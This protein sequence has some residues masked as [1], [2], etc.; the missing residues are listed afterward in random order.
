M[1]ITSKFSNATQQEGNQTGVNFADQP[2]TYT[3]EDRTEDPKMKTQMIME[4]LGKDPSEASV[5]AI[6]GADWPLYYADLNVHD[7]VFI[8]I[9]IKQLESFQWRNID[10]DIELK[11]K[12]ENEYRLVHGDMTAKEKW[13]AEA[14]GNADIVDISNIL[15]YV[16]DKDLVMDIVKWY[17]AN[18]KTGAILMMG[19]IYSQ[20]QNMI[21][22]NF[23]YKFI[24]HYFFPTVSNS[25]ISFY[26]V[27]KAPG[28]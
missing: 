25:D 7:G 12:F 10:N 5:V 9:N 2:I 11:E 26:S 16:K 17:V 3:A 13:L 15:D 23:N 4:S 20:I 8:D 19:S 14:I 24:K 22:Q 27:I 1:L 18:M 21:D 6:V 28:K